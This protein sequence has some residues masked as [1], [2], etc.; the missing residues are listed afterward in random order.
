MNDEA[1]T[2]PEAPPAARSDAAPAPDARR[3]VAA[4]PAARRRVS[5][6][7]LRAWAW[8]AAG[9]SFLLPWAAFSA[10]PRPV[11]SSAHQTVVVPAGWRVVSVTGSPGTGGAVKLV[12]PAGNAAGTTAPVATTGGSAP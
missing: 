2:P 8:G 9:V 12:A 11:A 4:R 3:P 10:A 5:R 6:R 1:R 7:A